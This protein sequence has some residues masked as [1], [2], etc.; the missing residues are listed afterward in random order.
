MEQKQLASKSESS[1]GGSAVQRM[2]TPQLRSESQSQ[3]LVKR[4]AVDGLAALTAA[5]A[6]SPVMVVIDRYAKRMIL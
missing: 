4:F 5:I 1:D 2:A 3:N 6:V